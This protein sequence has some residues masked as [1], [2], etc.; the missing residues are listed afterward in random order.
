MCDPGWSADFKLLELCGAVVR[1]YFQLLL[2]ILKPVPIFFCCFRES[3]NA[4]LLQSSRSDLWFMKLANE[5]L[6]MLML[7]CMVPFF[8]IALNTTRILPSYLISATEI[9][10]VAAEQADR[11]QPC[12]RSEAKISAHTKL[13]S[14]NASCVFPAS[15]VSSKYE[16]VCVPVLLSADCTCKC[17]PSV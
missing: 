1:S 4:V 7:I 2:N 9:E 5:Q 10:Q 14:K 12:D 11:L 8:C 15:C 16:R 17:R 6:V 3:C 13:S